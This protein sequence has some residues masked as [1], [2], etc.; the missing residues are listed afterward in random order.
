[1]K[2]KSALLILVLFM[3]VG[4]FSIVPY[5]LQA[6]FYNP[7]T[8][9]KTEV[10]DSKVVDVELTP[11]QEN[12]ILQQGKVIIR[13]EY[14]LTCEKCL[15]TQNILG[16]LVNLK[17]FENQIFVEEIKSTSSNLPKVNII[18]FVT[19]SNQIRVGEKTLQGMNV[20]ET[21]IINSLCGLML[22]P[23]VECALR[24]V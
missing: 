14:D 16:Q 3:L 4:G 1:M 23:P 18:G 12:A 9:Q 21:E 19:D 2:V 8:P 7:S 6:A 13:F 11:Q 24:N 20:T 17:Q 10:P 15:E 5:V 22:Q